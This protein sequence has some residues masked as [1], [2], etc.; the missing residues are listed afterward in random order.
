[1]SR[2]QQSAA[3]ITTTDL[4]GGLFLFG[5]AGCN[6]LALRGDDGALLVDGGIAAN[7]EPLLRAVYAA[8]RTT[9]VDTLINTHWH[10]EAVGANELVGRAG[11]KIFAHEKTAL[12]LGSR[13]S[14]VTF[15]GKRD[16]LPEV[17]RPTET[18]RGEGSLSFGSHRVAYGYLPAAHTDGDL[19][20][21]FADL[22]VMAVGGVVSAQA[23]PLLDYRNGA[24]LGGR[25]RA[26][27]RLASLV[28]P[29]TRVVPAD[30]RTMTGRDVMRQREIY[31][32]LFVTMV[33][34]MNKGYGAEDVVRDNPLKQYQAELGDPSAFL[35]GAYRSMLIAY[36]PD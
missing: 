10:P 11:G 23:W 17:A 18:T 26:V 8:T 13:V 22:D 36:V 25:V 33:N 12:Y 14:S 27:E 15:E 32:A 5:G 30:G 7:A 24:W 35:D 1:M 2:A 3:Q 28:K 19:F 9:R 29:D 31:D 20:V 4:G 21:H 34:F 6:V 16:P